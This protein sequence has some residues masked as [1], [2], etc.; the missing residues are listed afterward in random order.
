M[1]NKYNARRTYSYLCN[2]YFSSI[3][4]ATRGEE[5]CLLEKAGGISNLQ[6][7]IPFVL[8]NKPKVTITID[9]TYNLDGKQIFE[10]VKGMGE[11]REFRVKRIWLKQLH[12]IDVELYKK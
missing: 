12:G 2:R 6:Y 9:F 5:L 1:N 4:E 10:D 8:N 7:Q 3:I 11:T